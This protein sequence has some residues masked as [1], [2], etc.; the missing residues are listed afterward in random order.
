MEVAGRK[1]ISFPELK[2]SF[3]VQTL[4][5]GTVSVSARVVGDPQSTAV[6]T[7]FHMTTKLGGAANLN[8][9]HG[10][11]VP[12]GHL[13]SMS[14]T[15]GSSKGPENMG[16]LQRPFHGKVPYR[17]G[18]SGPSKRSMGFIMRV[19]SFLVIWR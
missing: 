15:I 19:R 3:F 18:F 9:T 5:L 1:H 6:I 8:G 7:L 17:V 14:I 2:P 11:Q 10:T 16:H 12:E 13:L 4:A